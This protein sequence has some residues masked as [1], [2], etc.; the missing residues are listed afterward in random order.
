[1]NISQVVPVLHLDNNEISLQ[2]D[3]P[4]APAEE[5]S[6]RYHLPKNLGWRA[7]EKEPFMLL[8]SPTGIFYHWRWGSFPQSWSSIRGL[9]PCYAAGGWQLQRRTSPPYS[10]YFWFLV[11]NLIILNLIIFIIFFTFYHFVSH[12]KL[13]QHREGGANEFNNSLNI[14]LVPN[15]C[16]RRQLL[17][18]SLCS[19]FLLLLAYHIAT[20][21]FST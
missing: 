20:K 19:S 10:L 8:P 11:F 16:S 7:P 14:S 12:P 6:F 3:W 4:L 18:D 1:M 17:A 9:T 15:G 21:D 13:L 2:W 5:A